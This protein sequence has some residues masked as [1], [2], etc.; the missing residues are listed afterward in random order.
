MNLVT[1]LDEALV[2]YMTPEILLETP[3]LSDGGVR[4]DHAHWA[5]VRREALTRA[6]R[7]GT[8]PGTPAWAGIEA[9]HVATGRKLAATL[10]E[11]AARAAL[12]ARAATLRAAVPPATDPVIEQRRQVSRE[13]LAA[14]PEAS[15]RVRVLL[16]AVRDNVD[17]ELIAAALSEPAPRQLLSPGQRGEVEAELIRRRTPAVVRD[18]YLAQT[19]R[20][21][22]VD[23]GNAIGDA[24]AIRVGGA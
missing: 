24:T 1:L 19:C 6:E 4:S 10:L 17:G 16:Q 18:A 9:P 14:M 15:D 23:I 11:R 12:D 20:R 7:D 3:D 2:P 13:K 8:R 5:T 21:I 22:A